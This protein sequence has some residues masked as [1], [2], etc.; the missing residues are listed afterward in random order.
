MNFLQ[1]HFAP[2]LKKHGVDSPQISPLFRKKEGN[3][4]YQPHVSSK[5]EQNELVENSY[6]F[7][8]T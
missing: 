5:K 1:V 4:G 7:F 6:S 2:F 8:D 3:S